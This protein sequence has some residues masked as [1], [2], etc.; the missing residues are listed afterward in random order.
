VEILLNDLEPFMQGIDISI[1]EMI[2]IVYLDFIENIKQQE[3]FVKAQM[4][5][6]LPSSSTI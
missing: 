3:N 4:T 1:N 6:P 2:A 5:L